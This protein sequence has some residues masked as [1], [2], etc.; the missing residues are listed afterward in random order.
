MRLKEEDVN[1]LLGKRKYKDEKIHLDNY[2]NEINIVDASE[3][4]S[5]DSLFVPNKTDA[6]NPDDNTYSDCNSGGTILTNSASI[7]SETEA[8][9][10]IHRRQ[11][12]NLY[13]RWVRL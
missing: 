5:E 10:I 8:K 9:E 2:N 6:S 1:A 4:V 7:E 12:Y 3:D 11:Y 13:P